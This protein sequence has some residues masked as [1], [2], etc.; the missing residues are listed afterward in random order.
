VANE[1]DNEVSIYTLNSDR[2]DWN[3][4]VIGGEHSAGPVLL[5]IRSD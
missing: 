5:T 1:N 3:N 4:T 2:Y